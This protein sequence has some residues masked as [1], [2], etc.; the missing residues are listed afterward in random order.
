[1]ESELCRYGTERI[2]VESLQRWWLVLFSCLF[3]FFVGC[4]REIPTY[5]PADLP[6]SLVLEQLEQRRNHFSSLRAVGALKVKEGKQ[7]WSGRAFLITRIPHSLRLEIVGFLGE[8]LLYV[9]SDGV[10]F[11][12]WEPGRNRAY[13]GL[14]SDSTLASLINFPLTDG[15]ALLL[16]AGIVPAWDFR[17]AKL[18]KLRDSEDLMLQL[19]D[20]PALQTLRVWLE[21][22]GL[23]VTRIERV[24]GG[25]R[26]LAATF[27]DFVDIEG[28]LYP[29]RIAVEGEKFHLSLQYKEF[30][31][32]E[33]LNQDA[34][35]LALPEGVE[36]LPW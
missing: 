30:A 2:T 28:F 24:L 6:V 19:E 22:D 1:M 21:G 29:K 32:N 36:V 23:T 9:A 17:E 12:A 3:F 7:R 34:F 31:V 16:M 13:H 18:F 14:A 33:P 10:Q 4:A 35:H 27:A 20:N 26:D 15:E 8:P 5:E 25:E 11:L